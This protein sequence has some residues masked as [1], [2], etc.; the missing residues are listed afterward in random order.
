M[1][2]G[3]R[4]LAAIALLTAAGLV[5]AQGYPNKPV[6]VVV[7]FTAGGPTDTVARSRPGD[8]QIAGTK[9]RG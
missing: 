9:R 6:S 2:K 8:E 4:P 1:T 5:A 3:L 7:P